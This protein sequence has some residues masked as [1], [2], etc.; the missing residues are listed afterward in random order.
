MNPT[1]GFCTSK[2][3]IAFTDEPPN[4]DGAEMEVEFIALVDGERVV[5]SITVEALEDYFGAASPLEAELLRAF[6]GGRARIH[7]IAR[8]AL[9]D[10][11]GRPVVLRSGMFRVTEP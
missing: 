8:L 2:R 5:C 6:E 11:D 9:Q 7:K 4:F 10:N 3:R 1:S